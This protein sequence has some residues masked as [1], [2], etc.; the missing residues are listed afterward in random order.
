MLNEHF[1]QLMQEMA[2]E[3]NYTGA[4]TSRKYYGIYFKCVRLP[5]GNFAWYAEGQPIKEA[6][7]IKS[8]AMPEVK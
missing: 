2:A 5:A 8:T 1:T 4:A 3:C 6:T 7:M